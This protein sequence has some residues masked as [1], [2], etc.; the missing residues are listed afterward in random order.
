MTLVYEWRKSLL[1]PMFMHFTFNTIATSGMMI[2]AIV[3]AIS[4]VLGVAGVDCKQGVEVTSIAPG[5]GAADT[6]IQPGDIITHFNGMPIQNFPALKLQTA[7]H[8]AG[9]TRSPSAHRLRS[10]ASQDHRA[11]DAPA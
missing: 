11:R 4:P 10:R 5:S 6:D 2:L 8:K 7:M 3:S 1:A 9:S